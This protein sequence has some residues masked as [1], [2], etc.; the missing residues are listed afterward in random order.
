LFTDPYLLKNLL[1]IKE[2]LDEAEYTLLLTTAKEDDPTSS[3]DRLI[4]S[5]YF[6]GAIIMETTEIR[7]FALYQ[8]LVDQHKPWVVMGFPGD[9]PGC[10]TVYVD[11][12]SGGQM[13]ARHLLSLGHRKFGIVTA[14]TRPTGVDERARGFSDC[15]KAEGI[16]IAADQTFYGDFSE[17]SGYRIAPQLLFRPNRPTAIFAIN[18]RIALGI[19]KWAME[20][21]LRV[22]DDFSIVG[23]DDIEI[24]SLSHPGLT[25]IR[26]P[27]V[28][29]GHSAAKMVLGLIR[30]EAV[31][32]QEILQTELVVRGTT[33]RVSPG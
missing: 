3:F 27:G 7:K 18:D 22:P 2:T 26:Q 10:H 25:T 15:L 6:D 11:D 16:E 12:Y 33:R 28:E 31:P 21:R 17:E 13:V 23:Y 4:R 5:R 24:A 9:I 32:M 14:T 1:G 19:M 20:Q 30:G 8:K 29:I